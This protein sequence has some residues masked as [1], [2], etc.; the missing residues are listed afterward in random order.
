LKSLPVISREHFRKIRTKRAPPSVL[1]QNIIND[2][3]RAIKTIKK[4]SSY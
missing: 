2:P 1:S 3:R 4:Q